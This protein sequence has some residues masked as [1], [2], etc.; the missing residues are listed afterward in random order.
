MFFVESDPMHQFQLKKLFELQLP[1]GID[2]SFT[3]SSLWMAAAVA[4]IAA[5]LWFGTSG[6]RLIP[7][8]VQ[9]VVELFYTFVRDMVK[10]IIGEDGLPYFP[11]V[12]TLFA[13]ILTCNLI[14]MFPYAFTVTSHISVT[15][16]L[17]LL[18]FAIVVIVGL[19]NKGPIG[20]LAKFLPPGTP[21][22]LAPVVY[23]LEVIS[24]LIRPGTL[25]VRLF[26]NMLAGHSLLKVL[27]GFIP[28]GLAAG[29]VGL[30]AALGSALGVVSVTALEFLVAFLQAYVFAILT[31]VYLSEV[32]GEGHH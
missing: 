3:N 1:N 32:V 29:G 23:I 2:V 18:V 4:I 19:I 27:A 16:A 5:L 22:V 9:S 20:F 10:S 14:G 24:F 26:A 17:G 7:S 28:A 13:F 6:A 21:L 15:I 30:L 31:C 11:I 25:A 8:R 12:F